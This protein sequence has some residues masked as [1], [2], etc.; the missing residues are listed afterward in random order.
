MKNDPT[1]FFTHPTLPAQRLYE[2]L[3]AYYIEYQPFAQ[4][5]KRFGYKTS[6]LYV[7]A[8]RW[9]KGQLPPFFTPQ[10]TG[11][12]RQPKKAVVRDTIIRLRKSNHSVYDIHRVLK[13]ERRT[14]SVRAIWEILKEA[15]FS[16][17]PRRLDEER[18]VSSKPIPAA[19]ADCRQ[20]SLSPREFKTQAGGLFLFLPFLADLRIDRLVEQAGYPGTRAIPALRYFLSL[21]S[22]KLLSRERISH[23]MDAVH[24]PGAALWCGLN[25]L[26]KTT[27]LTT[28]SYRIH[29]SQNLAFLKLWNH[30]LLKTGLLKGKSFNLDFHAIAHFGDDSILEK[31]YVPRRSHSEKSVMTFLAQ[32]GDSTV[33][34]YSQAGI[35]KN[36]QPGQAITFAH[37][38][39]AT[40]GHFPSELVFD[41]KLT[42]YKNLSELN[43]LGIRFLTLRRKTAR[44]V[45]QLM[46]F[47]PASWTPCHLDV[48]HRKYKNP[49]IIDKT[50]SLDDYQGPLRQIAAKDLGRELPTLLITND[51]ATTA[52]TLL[53][54]Y[55]KRML[56]ENAIADG[57]HFF[58]L[59]A[60]CSS[61]HVEIDFSVVLTVIANGLYHLLGNRLAGFEQATAKQLHRKIVNTLAH[62]SINEN[63]TI[64]V[65][66]PLRAHNPMLLEAG[67]HKKIISV[68]WL[69]DVPITFKFPSNPQNP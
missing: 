9:R 56:I 65:H 19:Y 44:V 41:S 28:Y 69:C 7:M 16:R 40:T 68:S 37:F 12:K 26:P 32:D 27:A 15:G 34:C 46:A 30:A 62:I 38:W 36:E 22:L 43:Q 67:Y 13:D 2:A 18:P 20:F 57:V 51:T 49:K 58:H 47:P 23:V 25:V 60:L 64:S 5:A 55:A 8:S 33:L 45:R 39:K 48:P 4:I 14:L 3:R 21:L 52:P 66:F 59:D 35:L 50:I 53:T 1:L 6:T 11:P 29:R 17:L 63:N 10:R 24:D 42:T 61:L 31:N 54:R